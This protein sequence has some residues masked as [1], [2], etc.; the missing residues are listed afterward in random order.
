MKFH[1]TPLTGAFEVE[2]EPKQ[3]ERGFL[4]RSFCRDAFAAQGLET[5]IAQGNISHNERRHTLRGL[6]YQAAPH[7]EAKLVSCIAGAIYDV[8]VDLRDDSPTRARWY[9]THL[10]ADLPRALYVPRGFAHGFLTLTEGARVLYQMFA[11]YH[12]ESARGVRWDDPAFGIE[13]PHAPQVMSD[14]DRSFPLYDPR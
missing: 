14:R 2:L 13:W 5:S 4:A 1:P 7:G 9:G 6:H 8:V 10:S 3:D 11:T 12:P